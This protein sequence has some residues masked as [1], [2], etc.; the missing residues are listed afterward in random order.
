M[1]K[2]MKKVV[3]LLI[4]NIIYYI[5][6]EYNLISNKKTNIKFLVKINNKDLKT[7]FFLLQVYNYFC[8]SNILNPT[9]NLRLKLISKKLVNDLYNKLKNYKIINNKV[10][11]Y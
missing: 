4:F 2:I 9:E 7:N 8:K 1:K 10:N 11:N 5:E 3:F 6:G